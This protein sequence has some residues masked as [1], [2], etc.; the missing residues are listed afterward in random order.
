MFDGDPPSSLVVVTMFDNMDKLLAWR[1]L[2]GFQRAKT[3]RDKSAIV[4]SFA[5]EGITD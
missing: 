2:L 4:R 1:Q 3:V 5:V